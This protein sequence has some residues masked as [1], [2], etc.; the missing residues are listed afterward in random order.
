MT[1][2]NFSLFIIAGTVV[3]ALLV[4]AI[5]IFLFQI[6]KK[7]QTYLYE[8][9][10]MKTQ[11]EQELLQTQ[12]EI[13]E[14]TLKTISEEIHDNVG[15]V[16]SLAKL[17]LNTFESNSEQKLQD[18]KQLISKAINDLRDLSRSMHGDR[19][20]ELGLQQSLTDE[21]QILENSGEFKTHLKIT[22]ESY[23][24]PPQ[25]EMVLFRIV[26]EALNNGIKHAKAKNIT[27]QLNYKPEVFTLTV[28]DDGI[29]FDTTLV[30]GRKGIGLKS[31]QNRAQLI[32]GTCTLQSSP[33][34]GVSITIEL[35]NH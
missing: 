12:L 11:F 26:Q 32:G 8:K 3:F 13:Q 29:G 27:L 7:N 19:I 17:N 21:L 10:L 25:K 30:Q 34:S 5:M 33:G 24:L 35:N 14:Q 15:Q 23:K 1:D 18:T 20:A 16:L 31:M 2:I 4:T 9:Q 28:A 6:Q 22:G